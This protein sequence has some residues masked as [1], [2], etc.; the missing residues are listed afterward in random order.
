[1][2][3]AVVRASNLLIFS[4]K[5]EW[6]DFCFSKILSNKR[7][8]FWDFGAEALEPRLRDLSVP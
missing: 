5:F 3:R 6:D 8:K 2:E 7:D 1:M 4:Q